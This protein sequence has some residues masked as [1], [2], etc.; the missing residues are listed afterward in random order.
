[1]AQ[2]TVSRGLCLVRMTLKQ[3][4]TWR[5]KMSFCASFKQCW[6]V[7]ERRART[8]FLYLD[9]FVSRAR[10]EVISGSVCRI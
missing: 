10:E 4:S 2:A 7:D 5:E 1:M 3:L 6:F 9:V 8:R